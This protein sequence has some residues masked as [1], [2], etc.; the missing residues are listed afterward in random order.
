MSD[1]QFKI[2]FLSILA[3]DSP[4]HVHGAMYMHVTR[5]DVVQMT[6]EGLI[7]CAHPSQ[8]G[9]ETAWPAPAMSITDKGREW[10]NANS[11]LITVTQTYRIGVN[12]EPPKDSKFYG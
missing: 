2:H 6:K 10:L 12:D 5:A 1:A 11:R 9:G 3:G 4:G 8:W 7:D